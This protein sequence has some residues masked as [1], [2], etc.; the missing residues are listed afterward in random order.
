M[1]ANNNNKTNKKTK[2]TNKPKKKKEK[3]KL[4]EPDGFS[5]EFYQTFKE[6]MPIS[7]KLFHKIEGT[8]ANSFYEATVTSI[9]IKTQQ[10]K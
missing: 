3:R 2:Q 6:F 1:T 8:L 7:L 10:R 9:P 4:Q 5:T